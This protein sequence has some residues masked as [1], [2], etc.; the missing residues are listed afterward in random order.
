MTEGESL[1]CKLWRPW[2][3]KEKKIDNNQPGKTNFFCDYNVMPGKPPINN[4]C[5]RQSPVVLSVNPCDVFN[6]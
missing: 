1:K 6:F 2:W 4:S 5:Y 3:K